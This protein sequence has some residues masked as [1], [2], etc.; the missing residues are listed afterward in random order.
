M[1]VTNTK[2]CKVTLYQRCRSELSRSHFS[3]DE[4]TTANVKID[5]V[6]S[7]APPRSALLRLGLVLW[8][9]QVL[10]YDI[11]TYPPHNLYIYMG[12]LTHWGFLLTICYLLCSMMCSV[13]YSSTNT[14]LDEPTLLLKTTWIVY[15]IAA[16]LEICICILYWTAISNGGPVTYVSVMEH[17]VF[18]LIVLLDGLVIGR[19]PI[20]VPHVIYFWIVCQLYLVWTLIDAYFDIGNGEWGPAYSD[21]AL[22]PVVNWKE[23]AQ[24]A[25]RVSTFC[26][27]VLAPLIFGI[28]WLMSLLSSSGFDGARRKTR[29]CSGSGDDE[30][31]EIY[32]RM[33]QAVLV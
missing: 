1:D 30:T 20:R 28:V 33:D 6:A 22:Y 23:Q 4:P 17:G 5:A 12:F 24:L 9:I 25:S 21:D 27:G 8:S 26:L 10:Y 31:S 11:T 15:S 14:L 29:L 3:L 2:P 19:I 7:F 18:A 13:R 32:Y 16:P